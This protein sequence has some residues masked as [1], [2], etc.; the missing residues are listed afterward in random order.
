MKGQVMLKHP[1]SRIQVWETMI[2][3]KSMKPMKFKI[4]KV[5]EGI[6]NL[7]ADSE[8]TLKLENRKKESRS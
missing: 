2:M 3:T 6:N 7:Q 4:A 8:E 5:N 1:T